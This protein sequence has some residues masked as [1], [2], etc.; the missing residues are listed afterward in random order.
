MPYF[1]R[2]IIVTLIRCLNLIG[3]FGRRNSS[4][5]LTTSYLILYTIPRLPVVSSRRVQ[6][7]W[8][9]TKIGTQNTVNRKKVRDSRMKLTKLSCYTQRRCVVVKPN[10]F[11]PTASSV[12]KRDGILSVRWGSRIRK[13]ISSPTEGL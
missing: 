6:I 13:T 5:V 2:R 11:V 8:Q 7:S 9:R 3:V 10:H 1:L 4:T 12:L